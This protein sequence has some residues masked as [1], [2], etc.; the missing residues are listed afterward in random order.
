MADL[1]DETTQQLLRKIVREET[2]D[3]RRDVELIKHV[4]GSQSIMLR[5]LT[6]DVSQLK[7]S[8]RWQGVLFEDLE[9]R[10]SVLAE[11]VS[12]TLT[13]RQQVGDH[14]IR[15]IQIEAARNLPHIAA[16]LNSKPPRKP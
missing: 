1:A 10:F 13:L 16:R 2:D 3:I 11:A 8:V 5:S 12:D 6:T 4:Q 14:E 7:Q 15:L 9:D